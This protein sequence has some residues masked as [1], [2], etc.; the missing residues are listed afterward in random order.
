MS[1]ADWSNQFA[2][3]RFAETI[4]FAFLVHGNV[5]KVNTRIIVLQSTETGTSSDHIHADHCTQLYSSYLGLLCFGDSS[6]SID[7]F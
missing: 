4:T 6:T 7:S 2:A 5:T 3:L 1:S